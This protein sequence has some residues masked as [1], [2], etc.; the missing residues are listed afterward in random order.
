MLTYDKLDKALGLDS[1]RLA[2]TKELDEDTF[3]L[4]SSLIDQNAE[5]MLKLQVLNSQK[6]LV[7]IPVIKAHDKEETMGCPLEIEARA[8]AL[9][10]ISEA[11]TKARTEADRILAEAKRKAEKIV[12]EKTQF[13]IEQGLLII[14][15]AQERA[16]SILNEVR[17]QAEAITGKDNH[18]VKTR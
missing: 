15:K 5:I 18:R 12:E 11:E 14:N 10:I 16:L 8:K 9:A 4:I 13:A 7:N 17:K 3:A 1:L 6:E 2:V